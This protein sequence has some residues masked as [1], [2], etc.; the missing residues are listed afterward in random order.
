MP[1]NTFINGKVGQ[2]P[3]MKNKTVQTITNQHSP[4]SD[5][6]EIHLMQ[7]IES[8][9]MQFALSHRGENKNFLQQ[10]LQ[11]LRQKL[12]QLLQQRG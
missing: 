8:I 3:A 7:E 6:K 9:E 11:G 10:Q 5:H 2:L 4:L 1:Q 12:N